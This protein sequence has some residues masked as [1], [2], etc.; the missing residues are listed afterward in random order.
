MPG[1]CRLIAVW[2]RSQA[3]L[4]PLLVATEQGN[5]ALIEALIAAKADQNVQDLSGNSAGVLIKK[6]REAAAAAAAARS[7]IAS[8]TLDVAQGLMTIPGRI[9]VGAIGGSLSFF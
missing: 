8:D 9:S 2:R 7:Q 5:L 1:Q 4:T 3:G 6:A